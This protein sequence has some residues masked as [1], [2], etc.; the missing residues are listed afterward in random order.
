MGA[1]TP[2]DPGSMEAEQGL[3]GAVLI[4]NEALR[5]VESIVQP[6]DFSEPLHAH[7]WA[8]IIQSD[9]SGRRID[10]KLLASSIGKD[11]ALPLGGMTVTQYIARLAAEAT[12]VI[13]APD[14]ARAIR[15]TADRKRMAEIGY[16]L[17]TAAMAD[18]CDVATGAIDA[19]DEILSLRSRSTTPSISAAGAA[20]RVLDAAAHA[21]QTDG[22]QTGVSWGLSAVDRKTLGLQCGE[23]AV[24]AGRPG[25]GKTAL[26]LCVARSAAQ[27]GHKTAF[28]SLEMGDVAISQRLLADLLHGIMPIAYWAIRAGKFSET[29]F[30]EIKNAAEGLAALP[31]QIE[32]QPALTI[33]QIAARARQRKRRHGLDFLVV[34]HLHLVR[35]SERYS[36]HRVEE[37][38]ETT[39]GLKALAKELEVPVLAL[40][41]LSRGVEGRDDK[42]PTLADLRGSGDIEQ[43]ADTVAMLYRESYYLERKKPDPSDGD[44]LAKWLSQI[45][46]VRNRLDV[47]IEKQRN[48][49]VGTIQVFCSIAHNAIRDLVSVDETN[50]LE[51]F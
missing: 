31:L 30:V 46:K 4:N 12:T 48:G 6:D 47:Q 37:I 33:A 51:G 28:F 36:G 45:E 32:Q 20:V 3:L 17:S 25:M 26:G 10:P 40:C 22:R 21:Y 41:Q 8:V 15:D 38:G 24:L 49:P 50:K 1:I 39:R 16:R 7:L 44:E 2:Q 42:R 23:L 43:D 18:P 9:D 29:E 34:D 14:Y 19:L 5:L 11:A 27:A 13:N 35:P